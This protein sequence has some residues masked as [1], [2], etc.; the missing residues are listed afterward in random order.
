MRISYIVN[1][2]SLIMMYIGIVLVAPALVAVYYH[3]FNSIFPFISAALISAGTGYLL[4]KIVP[5]STQLENL[6]DIKK[7]EGLFIVAAS[8]VI[9]ALI[10]AIPYPFFNLSIIN[11]LFEATSGITTTGATILTH[12]DYPKAFFFWRSFTQWIGGMGIIIMFIAVLP[13]FAVAGRQMFFAEAPGPTEDKFTPRVRNTAS[14]L[15]KLYLGL[16][17][18]LICLLKLAGMPL[19]DAVCNSL[20]TMSAGGFSPHPHSIMGYDMPLITCIITFFMILAGTSF[21]LQYK[22][23]QQRNPLVL[24]KDEEFR[25]YIGAIIILSLIIAFPLMFTNYYSI[26]DAFRHA[27]FHVVSLMTS[28][29]FASSTYAQ[30]AYSAQ[31]ILVIAMILSSCSS[32]AGGG[33]KIARLL[34]VFKVLKNEISKVLHPNAVIPV[35]H[36]EKAVSTEVLRQVIIFVLQYLAIFGVSAI[37]VTLIEHSHTIGFTST[38]AAIGNIGPAFGEIGPMGSFDGMQVSTKIILILNMLV[39][40]LELIPFIVMLNPEFWSF[41]NE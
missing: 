38:F 30:W 16:T 34:L 2:L 33:I 35:K 14:I 3:D 7:S 21:N 6:N 20:S 27:A 41:K 37:I 4:R 31:I 26:G 39:G 5:S 18:L 17:I 10:A 8:W 1:A 22:A 32:S 12:F 9:F 11:S 40:R 13:Q 28:S 29:G 24:F 36:N 25:V 23:F 15:W 19:F